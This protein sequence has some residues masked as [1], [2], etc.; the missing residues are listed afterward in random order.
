VTRAD[1]EGSCRLDVNADQ[2]P[3]D[4]IEQLPASEPRLT[5]HA[6]DAKGYVWQQGA[7]LAAESLATGRQL[8]VTPEHA[9]HVLEIITAARESQETGRRVALTSTFGWP[10]GV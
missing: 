5:R 10:V 1:H 3:T 8:L 9:L 4:A 6:T 2:I 7:A